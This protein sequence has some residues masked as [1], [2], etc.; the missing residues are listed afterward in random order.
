MNE[1]ST[2]DLARVLWDYNQ[3][4]QKVEKAD[5]II[6]LGSHD[7][8]I[9]DRG[10]ELYFQKF[11]PIIL[12]SGG[13]GRLTDTTWTK[14]EA[15]VFAEIAI[16]MGVPRKDILIENKS[17]NSK[18]NLNFSKK[19]LEKKGVTV[20]YV[21]LVH[22]PYFERRQYAT[23]QMLF[24]EIKATITS[25]QMSYDEYLNGAAKSREESINIIVGETQRI[26]IYP[27]KGFMVYQE[28]PVNVWEAYLEL[29]KRGFTNQLVKG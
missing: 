14:P 1:K 7:T 25:P 15:E 20:H 12:F 26:K 13:F 18:E 10:V 16:K 17:T 22:K 6:A 27:S 21:I 11:A 3:L 23:W 2:D 19:L 24:P 4:H 5:A 8:R 29:V 28:I 9:A